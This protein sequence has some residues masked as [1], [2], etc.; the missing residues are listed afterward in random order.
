[1]AAQGARRAWC[2][3][4]DLCLSAYARTGG[5]VVHPLNRIKSVL[6]AARRSPLFEQ[7]GYIRACDITGKREVLHP[8][9]MLR[10]NGVEPYA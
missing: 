1:M 8:Q 9:F 6:D 5:R 4:P 10:H 2:G 3:D 7:R